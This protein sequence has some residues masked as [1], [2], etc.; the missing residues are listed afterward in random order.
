M[1]VQGKDTMEG[2]GWANSYYGESK[3]AVWEL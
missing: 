3:G 1:G 2:M